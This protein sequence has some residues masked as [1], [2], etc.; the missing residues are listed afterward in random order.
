LWD[1]G[2]ITAR[3]L[4]VRGERDSQ[5]RPE[6]VAWLEGDLT[7]V[8]STRTVTLPQATHFVHLDRPERG[9]ECLIDQVPRSSDREAE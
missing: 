2:A 8:T 9:R 1:A 6:D 4:I 3:V 5:G 7:N